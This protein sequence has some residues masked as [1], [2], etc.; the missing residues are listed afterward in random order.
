[1]SRRNPAL[2]APILAIVVCASTAAA[3]PPRMPPWMNTT[4]R[5]V[6]KLEAPNLK[7]PAIQWAL[8]DKNPAPGFKAR[9]RERKSYLSL[10]HREPK[11]EEQRTRQR[12]VL[13]NV[14]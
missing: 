3:P 13:T 8:F 12:N 10:P 6:P 2:L 9:L 4:W 11:N 1:M 14:D 7:P 5:V